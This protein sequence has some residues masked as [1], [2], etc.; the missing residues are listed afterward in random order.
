MK[1]RKM[2]RFKQQ[3]TEE[4]CVKVLT[5]AWRGVLSIHGENGYPYGVPIDF[6]YD[7]DD[8]KVYF[9]GA[10]EGSKIDLL[11]KNNKVCL[12]VMDEGFRKE[13]DWAL[14]IKSVIAFGT[15]E[16]VTDQALAMKELTKL[17]KKYYPTEEGALA[18]V[19]KDGAR[20]LMLALSIDHMTGKLV[21]E[22]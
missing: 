22:S 7:E 19:A 1:W 12:T 17:A 4:E 9:H 5:E 11:Q 8:G 20:T 14:N 15:I 16:T 6:F 13:N 2:R 21:N 3:I 18:E 10:K